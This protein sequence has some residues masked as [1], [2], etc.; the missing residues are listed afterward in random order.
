MATG[1]ALYIDSI[2]STVS[3][4]VMLLLTKFDSTLAAQVRSSPGG[5]DG[6]RYASPL[7]L[8]QI[9]MSMK[10][11]PSFHSSERTSASQHGPAAMF[12]TLAKLM[13]AV[14]AMVLSI[15]LTYVKC[16]SAGR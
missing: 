10:E 16:A 5:H 14:L 4:K 3:S 7:D 15:S 13:L 1:A 2:A 8:V 6:R 11:H 12:V 9:Q